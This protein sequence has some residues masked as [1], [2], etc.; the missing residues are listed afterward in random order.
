MRFQNKTVIVTG[1]SLGIGRAAAAAFAREGAAVALVSRDLANGAD[2]QR[3]I[4]ALGPGEVRFIATDLARE[5][6]I[7]RMVED[8]QQWGRIDVLVNNAGVYMQGDVTMTALA[9]WEQLMAVNVTGAF[10]CTKYVVPIMQAQGGGA[11]VNV[12]SEAGLVGIKNQVAYNVSKTAL[13]ALTQSCALDHAAQGI[14]VNCVCPGTTY[15]PLVEAALGRASDPTA[16]R[17][18][19]E[20]VRPLDRLGTSDEIAAAILYMASDEAG[21]TTGAVLSVDGG[22]T[23]Q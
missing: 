20:S 14:R 4:D 11:I 18:R 17:R 1:G 13:I 15:T 3:E 8:V 21:Y 23:A 2:A 22:Y 6:D 12:S 19:L 9:D 10:L 16:E 7:Q 5:A